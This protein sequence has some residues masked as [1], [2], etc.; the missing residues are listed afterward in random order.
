MGGSGEDK[1]DH[2]TQKPLELMR[3]PILNHT[4]RGELI[5][6]PFLGSGTSLMA[7]E[8]TGRIC[9]GLELDCKFV[10]VIVQ[11]WQQFTGQAAVLA[12]VGRS[13]DL[14]SAQRAR[15]R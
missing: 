12:D 15:S 2:P 10:D 9:H 11:R 5:Y 8:T 7:A 14:V 6:D 3:R 1:F 13:F 4:R